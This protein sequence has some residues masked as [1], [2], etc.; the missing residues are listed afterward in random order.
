[1][2]KTGGPLLVWPHFFWLPLFAYLVIG[3]VGHW[4]PQF[5]YFSLEVLNS[6]VKRDPS[7]D[8]FIEH[9]EAFYWFV[10]LLFY[11][12]LLKNLYAQKQSIRWVALFMLISFLAL[13]EELSWGQHFF[14]Y[15]TPKSLVEF[16]T[17]QEFN[18]HNLNLGKMLGIPPVSIFYIG[19][20]TELLNPLFYL[21]CIAVWM[22]F[23]ILLRKL[24]LRKG[25]F[26]EYP[27][28]SKH[29][30][31]IFAFVVA[32]YLLIDNLAFDCGEWFELAMATV[33][34]IT[35][36]TAWQEQSFSS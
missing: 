18:I 31:I 33:G 32:V 25:Y 30:C 1:M 10:G 27:E 14:Q 35:G 13:G 12:A 5:Q 23:P 7:E 4:V 8:N 11:G 21:L 15:Q 28:Q 24:N 36:A 2:T 16:N 19:S 6:G 3:L 9:L 34:A 17:Q 26:R 22:M 20:L 29:F